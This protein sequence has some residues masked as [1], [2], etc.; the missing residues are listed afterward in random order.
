MYGPGYP[1]PGRMPPPP[2]GTS[3][4]TVVLIILGVLFVLGA[5]SCV[6]CTGLIG[7]GAA[8]APD[9]ASAPATAVPGA[10]ATATPGAAGEPASDDD[11]TPSPAPGAPGAPAAD[12][13]AKAKAPAAPAAPA[14]AG[15]FFCNATGFVRVCGFANVCSNQLVSGTGSST[16]R[17]VATGLAMNACRGQ[18]I[19]R[20][21]AGSCT[22]ACSFR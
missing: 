19:A 6:V 16:D 1:S 8:A 9:P 10:N 3:A 11:T 2:Q 18:V 21:G 14:P 13:G 4:L 12:P 22:V 7:L 15:R 5:G 17:G 20:G